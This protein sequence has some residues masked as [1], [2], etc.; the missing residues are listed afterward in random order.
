MQQNFGSLEEAVF[1]SRPNRMVLNLFGPTEEPLICPRGQ[2]PQGESKWYLPHLHSCADPIT[3]ESICWKTSDLSGCPVTTTS[4]LAHTN[5]PKDHMFL[6]EG[7]DT[8]PDPKPAATTSGQESGEKG[9][10][11]GADHVQAPEPTPPA[12]SQEPR[13][14]L[15]P[16][17]A[18]RS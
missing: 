16:A 2:P 4:P 18:A 11:R 15:R 10:S 14:G 8:K 5:Q 7:E 13:L 1:S 3:S 9:N 6:C 12:D 17:L